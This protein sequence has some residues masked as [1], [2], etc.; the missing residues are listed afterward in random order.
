MNTMNDENNE[1]ENVT[2][3]SEEEKKQKEIIKKRKELVKLSEDGEIKQSVQFLKK[4]SDKVILK[5]YAEYENKQKK[6]TRF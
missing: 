2:T 6:Q 3:P 4:A 5:I 1:Y